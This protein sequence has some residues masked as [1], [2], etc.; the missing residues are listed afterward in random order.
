MLFQSL[1][2]HKLAT[3]MIFKEHLF[4]VACFGVSAYLC[5]QEWDEI[6]EALPW[7][8]MISHLLWTLLFLKVYGAEETMVAMVNTT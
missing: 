7:E 1:E 5:V 4:H 6:E 8:V 3:V 2:E